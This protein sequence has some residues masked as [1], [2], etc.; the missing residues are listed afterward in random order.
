MEEMMESM[1]HTGISGRIVRL[2][3]GRRV[4][5][6]AAGSQDASGVQQFVR[7]L[8]ARSRRNRFFSP[9]RELSPAQLDCMTRSRP[10]DEISLVCDITEGEESRI[11]AMAQYALCEPL[12]AEFAIVVDD[13]WQRQGLG[14]QLFGVLAQQA[15]RAG[16]AVLSGFVLPDNWP[17]LA[18]LARLDCELLTDSDPHLIRVVQRLDAREVAV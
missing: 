1:Q 12:D 5:L 13:A 18:L 17:M 15:T 9:V 10:P 2:R 14:T 8:S 3:D 4:T 16:L 11:V 7:G 6:R